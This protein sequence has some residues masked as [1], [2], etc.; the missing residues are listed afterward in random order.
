[1]T[2]YANVLLRLLLQRAGEDCN[3]IFLIEWTTTDW[4]SLTLDGERH[5]ASFAIGGP[6]P[7]RFASLWLAG[8]LASQPAS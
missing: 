6:E 8:Q 7:Q 3:R 2:A 1:M 4:H 5:V